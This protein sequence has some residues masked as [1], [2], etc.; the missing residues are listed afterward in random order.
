MNKYN[1][2]KGNELYDTEYGA[3]YMIVDLKEVFENDKKRYTELTDKS[4]F[5]NKELIYIK[6]I[7]DTMNINYKRNTVY[8]VQ[9]VD[10]LIQEIE[11]GIIKHIKKYKQINNSTNYKFLNE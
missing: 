2:K 3:T 6:I 4:C 9:P 11:E 1:F 10:T 8:F 7:K 5:I